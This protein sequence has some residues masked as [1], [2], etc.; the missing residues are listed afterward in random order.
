MNIKKTQSILEY[1][2]LIVILAAAFV[3]MSAY[4]KRSLQGRYK[5]TGDVFGGGFLYSPNATTVTQNGI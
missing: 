4:L 1:T 3:G 5:Q 2:L